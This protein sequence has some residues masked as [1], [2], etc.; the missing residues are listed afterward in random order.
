LAPKY[1][2][3]KMLK[4]DVEKA[5]FFVTKLKV[6]VLPCLLY[7]KNGVNTGRSI[8]FEDF[9]NEDSFPTTALEERMEKEGA[10]ILFVNNFSFLRNDF[11]RWFRVSTDYYLN[12]VTSRR[13]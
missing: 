9:G 12:T 13:I 7:F 2:A 1:P 8:G 11:A 3:I 6:R 10:F 4:I 5:P